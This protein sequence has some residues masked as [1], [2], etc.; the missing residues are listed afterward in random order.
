MSI[1]IGPGPWS[2]L[3]FVAAAL[4]FVAGAASAQPVAQPDCSTFEYDQKPTSLGWSTQVK[5]ADEE[6]GIDA[7]GG[8]R[9]RRGSAG[10]A[11]RVP[12]QPGQSV[13]LDFE[14]TNL[15]TG[16][17][18]PA[19]P[20]L[21]GRHHRPHRVEHHFSRGQRDRA[22]PGDLLATRTVSFSS[23][24]FSTAGINFNSTEVHL[25]P[26]RHA[27][28]RRP[29]APRPVNGP[30]TFHPYPAERALDRSPAANGRQRPRRS[31]L[32]R[33]PS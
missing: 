14:F 3:A 28:L 2:R 24:L 31:S 1:S 8:H 22:I 5:F 9:Q 19:E 17:V 10:R 21:W 13:G 25:E 7:R 15:G 4:T 6:P 20:F 27:T 33:R 12:H 29:A 16:T 11:H 32:R 23:L 30:S 26:S 18:D